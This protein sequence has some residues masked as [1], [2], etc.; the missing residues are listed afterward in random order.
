MGLINEQ[1]LKKLMLR[2]VVI[3]IETWKYYWQPCVKGENVLE[4]FM[5]TKKVGA[6]RE[7]CK[8][9]KAKK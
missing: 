2:W 1:I 9:N 7:A 8:E 3:A 6:D 4:S 5:P